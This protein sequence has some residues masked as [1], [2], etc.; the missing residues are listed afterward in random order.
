MAPT[1]KGRGAEQSGGERVLDL[2][3][4]A[5]LSGTMR[6]DVQGEPVG[7]VHVENG[8]VWEGRA[9]DPAQTVAVVENRGDF[10]RI[11]EGELNPVVAA[12]QGRLALQGDPELGTRL[13]YALNA[14]K[15][16]AKK[17]A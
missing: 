17:G 4:L 7:S 10:M 13:I 15:P 12:I 8:R 16:F 6:V 2:P 9:D 14:A 5:G 3:S 11:V 1:T